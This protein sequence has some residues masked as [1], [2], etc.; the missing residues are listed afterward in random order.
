MTTQPSSERPANGD[1]VIHV[2]ADGRRGSGPVYLNNAEQYG[3]D[4]TLVAV[5]VLVSGPLAWTYS[6]PKSEVVSVG[7]VDTE[8]GDRLGNGFTMAALK[9][10]APEIRTARQ[11]FYDRFPAF[12][13]GRPFVHISELRWPMRGFIGRTVLPELVSLSED[14][15]RNIRLGTQRLPVH[16][17]ATLIVH[18]A[19][20]ADTDAFVEPT[21]IGRRDFTIMHAYVAE[22]GDAAA[23]SGY[24]AA[25]MPTN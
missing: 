16:N 10:F 19:P 13:D 20:Q 5:S 6:L 11:A 8:P 12:E 24:F 15:V 9:R 18:A 23:H 22:A 14:D 17:D 25:P 1:L 7:H 2:P 21:A 3:S 4:E